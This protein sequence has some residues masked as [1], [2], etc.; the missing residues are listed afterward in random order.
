[1]GCGD[2][3]SSYISNFFRTYF[4]Q[5]FY[6]ARYTCRFSIPADHGKIRKPLCDLMKAC[7]MDIIYEIE[8]YIMGRECPGGVPFAKLVTTEILI[9]VTIATANSVGIKLVVKNEELPL[10]VNNHCQQVFQEIQ[11]EVVKCHPDWVL[12]PD[13]EENTGA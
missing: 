10:K 9:D 5:D 13:N 6:M 12:M 2:S 11:S 7:N 4:Y 1:L 8:D 3:V